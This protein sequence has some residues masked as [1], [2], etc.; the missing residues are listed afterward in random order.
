MLLMAVGTANAVT[1]F[2]QAN[3]SLTYV[4]PGTLPDSGTT[5]HKIF[6][7]AGTG[8]IFT[9]NIDSQDGLP[10]VQF[11]T[12]ANEVT[13]TADGHAQLGKGGGTFFSMDFSVPGYNIHD[14]I[15]DTNGAAGNGDN[16]VTVQAFFGATELFNQTVTNL[17]TGNFSWL[18]LAAVDVDF[19][20][21]LVT[22][23]TGFTNIGRM[24]VSGSAGDLTPTP[25][26][27]V[28][29]PAGIWLFG[30]AIA[31]LGALRIRR[32]RPQAAA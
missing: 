3:G 31:G 15:F 13:S 5:E 8:P 12:D 28:P 16:N 32:R 10:A 14:F 22:S 24:F 20:R 9:G 17:G 7:D 6:I 30:T 27:V 23:S 29:L 4:P 2:T 1:T 19:N 18:L 26:G 21:I 11:I 25:T